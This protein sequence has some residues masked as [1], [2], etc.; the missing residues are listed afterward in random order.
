MSMFL[1]MKCEC[2]YNMI[3]PVTMISSLRFCF[4][5]FIYMVKSYL[6][7]CRYIQSFTH[8]LVFK[9]D[10]NFRDRCYVLIFCNKLWKNNWTT[11][12]YFYSCTRLCIRLWIINW[13]YQDIILFKQPSRWCIFVRWVLNF[14][15]KR[16]RHNLNSGMITEQSIYSTHVFLVITMYWPEFLVYM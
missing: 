5:L 14:I 4:D 13:L 6:I 7:Y 11:L 15:W 12:N 16:E 2:L 3:L 8:C 10:F 9:N 1:T